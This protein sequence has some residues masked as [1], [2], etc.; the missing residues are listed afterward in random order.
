MSNNKL[1]LANF[2]GSDVV[3]GL[4]SACIVY[5]YYELSKLGVDIN[6]KII[7]L[8]SIVR[9]INKN[10]NVIDMQLKKHLVIHKTDLDVENNKLL[11]DYVS[12]NNN[13]ETI[14]TLES[15]IREL[16]K[17]LDKLEETKNPIH[18]VKSLEDDSSFYTA[19]NDNQGIRTQPLH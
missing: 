12:D 1:S 8:A 18:N 6:K 16:E 10:T 14:I 5:L 13:S 2:K 4:N 15:K 11:E 3:L 19:K 9:Q 7:G 17:R